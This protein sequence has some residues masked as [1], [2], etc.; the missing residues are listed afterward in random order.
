MDLLYELKPDLNASSTEYQN[1]KLSRPLSVNGKDFK[2]IGELKKYLLA[3]DAKCRSVCLMLSGMRCDELDAMDAS[4]S[5]QTEI[6]RGQTIYLFKSRQSKITKGSQTKEDTFVTTK[7]GHNAFK[8]LHAIHQPY[9][10]ALNTDKAKFCSLSRTRYPIEAPKE[11]WMSSQ[12]RWLNS[13]AMEIDVTLSSEDMAYINMSNPEQVKFNKGDSFNFTM[14]QFRRSFAYYVVGFE[15]MAF[16]QLKQQLSHLSLAMT[17]HYANNASTFHKLQKEIEVERSRQQS[18]I[19]ARIYK[20][21]ANN[22][23]IA[24]GKGKSLMQIAGEGTNYFSIEEN[25]RKMEPEYWRHLIENGNVHLHAIAPGMY[26]TNS[27]CSMRINIELAECVDCEF[28][29]IDSVLYAEGVRMNAMKNILVLEETGELT[30]NIMS[31]L[32]MKIKSCERIM[33]DLEYDFEPFTFSDKVQNTLI[34][35][36]NL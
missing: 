21:I 26:C 18:E 19:L 27:A 3:L 12:R 33:R 22:E 20:R 35:T 17:R 14:H 31:Q 34:G 2:S 13:K 30:T 36:V 1:E 7:N 29:L 25:K 6:V 28:D 5:A 9:L 11:V 10:K 8:L 23:R 24:G 15:L 32:A 16:P 4:Y